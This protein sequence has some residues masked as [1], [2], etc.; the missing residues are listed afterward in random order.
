M[1]PPR[2]PSIFEALLNGIA[3]QQL[4]LQAGLT[5][6]NRLVDA[7]GQFLD[8]PSRVEGRPFP[9]RKLSLVLTRDHCRRSASARPRA[10]PFVKLRLLLQDG[11]SSTRPLLTLMMQQHVQDC[12]SCGALAAG[13]R[14]M[15]SFA[16]AGASISYLATTSGHEI[17][18]RTGSGGNARWITKAPRDCFDAG[19]LTRE[20][21]TSI[22]CSSGLMIKR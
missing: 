6:L 11:S 20:W 4:S 10:L 12:R 9:N 17:I 18:C 16:A 22:C 3:C 5:L 1:R 13:R 2:L 15:F 8:H 19:S 21:S 14:S 7:F